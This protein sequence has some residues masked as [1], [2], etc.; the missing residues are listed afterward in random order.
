MEDECIQDAA[1]EWSRRMNPRI[2]TR[3][4]ARAALGYDPGPGTWF[5]MD[6]SALVKKIQD[7]YGHRNDD[8][9]V[10]R[11]TIPKGGKRD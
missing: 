11:G 3:S 8:T 5:C 10:E 9:R 2:L 6:P 7:T 4:E 1:I